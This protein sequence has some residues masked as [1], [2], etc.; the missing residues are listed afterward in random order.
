MLFFLQY[1]FRFLNMEETIRPLHYFAIIDSTE[2]QFRSIL[3]L[4][5]FFTVGSRLVIGQTQGDFNHLKV[6]GTNLLKNLLPSGFCYLNNNETLIGKISSQIFAHSPSAFSG[7]PEMLQE[8]DVRVHDLGDIFGAGRKVYLVLFNE[9]ATLVLLVGDD[10][11]TIYGYEWV[12]S[13]PSMCDFYYVESFKVTPEK[14]NGEKRSPL[15]F[16]S[17]SQG[18]QRV[19]EYDFENSEGFNIQLQN[20]LQPEE[21]PPTFYVSKPLVDLLTSHQNDL[22]KESI[23]TIVREEGFCEL[24]KLLS[25]TNAI[26]ENREKV[27]DVNVVTEVNNENFTTQDR[28]PVET[29]IRTHYN[30]NGEARILKLYIPVDVDFDPAEFE[31][32]IE[33]IANLPV[34]QI[35]RIY[36]KG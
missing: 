23:A 27:V 2:S 33:A 17:E 3:F 31:Q 30:L 35:G 13:M 22:T 15:V 34:G 7:L 10:W 16:N 8:K 26:E 21:A 19:D 25:S 12:S 6:G 20:S 5:D 11:S 28:V 1:Y 24:L 18:L 36:L 32:Q 9:P 4:R 14:N 29:I